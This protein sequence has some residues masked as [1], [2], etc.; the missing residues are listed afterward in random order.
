MIFE[1]PVFFF[2]CN[3]LLLL[4]HFFFFLSKSND[5]FA[6]H[7]IMEVKWQALKWGKTILYPKKKKDIPEVNDLNINVKHLNS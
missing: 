6:Y 2:F 7:H 5:L 4:K 3:V 1:G